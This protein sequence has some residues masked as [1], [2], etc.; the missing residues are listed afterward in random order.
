LDK[1]PLIWGQEIE[2]SEGKTVHEIIKTVRSI[3]GE[4]LGRER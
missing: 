1:E 2:E 3:T 4:E